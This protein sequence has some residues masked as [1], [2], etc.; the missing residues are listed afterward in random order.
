[1]ISA[2][3]VNAPTATPTIAH[4]SNKT[5]IKLN[6]RGKRCSSRFCKGCTKMTIKKANANGIEI[7]LVA[8]KA[9]TTR[10]EAITAISI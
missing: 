10:I 2:L 9:A 8:F 5:K 1:M 3:K 4:K 7:D 6:H